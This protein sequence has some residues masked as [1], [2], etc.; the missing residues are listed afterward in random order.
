M[1]NDNNRRV[2]IIAVV[3][4]ILTMVLLSIIIV[5]GSLEL[6]KIRESVFGIEKTQKE[7]VETKN[8]TIDID[9]KDK[10]TSIVLSI[11]SVIR[12]F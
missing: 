2:A 4:A 7:F 1:K 3:F 5:F 8:S 11:P 6:A 9:V 10:V 12:E